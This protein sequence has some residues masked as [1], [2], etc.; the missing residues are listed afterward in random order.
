MMSK[1]IIGFIISLV[2]Q[3]SRLF[4]IVFFKEVS[5]NFLSFQASKVYKCQILEFSILFLIG[6]TYRYVLKFTQQSNVNLNFLWSIELW[7]SILCQIHLCILKVFCH[8]RYFK[9]Q[10]LLAQQLKVW[11][12]ME[13]IL[14]FK[15][16]LDTTKK[17]QGF[18][19][20]CNHKMQE[21]NLVI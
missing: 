8:T 9:T 7:L 11:K 20:S 15:K 4:L 14:K 12:S 3:F 18:S 13:Y 1:Y 5:N 21:L 2:P 17:L 16:L 10:N 19:F 6:Q